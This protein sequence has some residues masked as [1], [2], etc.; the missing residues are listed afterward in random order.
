MIFENKYET[1]IPKFNGYEA[2]ST[3]NGGNITSDQYVL[4]SLESGLLLAKMKTTTQYNK[5]Y[6]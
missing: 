2:W 6:L 4:F 3:N 5:I 1:H